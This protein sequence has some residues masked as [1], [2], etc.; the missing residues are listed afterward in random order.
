MEDPGDGT[1]TWS[2]RKRYYDEHYFTEYSGHVS[3]TGTPGYLSGE[4]SIT[5]IRAAGQMVLDITD[6]PRSILDCGCATGWLVHGIKMADPEVEVKGFDV[7]EFAISHATP[8][9]APYLSV[10]DLSDGLPFADGSF[11]LVVGFDILEHQQDY[12]R[13][14]VAVT[15]MCRIASLKILLRQPMTEYTGGIWSSDPPEAQ[16][17]QHD[18]MATLNVLPHRARLAL[19]G[20]HPYIGPTAPALCNAIE[21]P[22]GHPRSF[23]IELFSSFGFSEVTLAE[24]YYIFPNALGLCSFNVLLFSQSG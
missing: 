11:E 2:D 17:A 22:L 5:N 8:E 20:V 3:P 9:M 4:E 23:W 6:N 16:R 15:E 14:V 21:H 19:V 10:A 13:L 7:S 24:H 12:D 18:W 1:Y